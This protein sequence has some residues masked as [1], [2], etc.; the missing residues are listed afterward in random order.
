MLEL[1]RFSDFELDGARF[2]LRRAG[3][4]VTLQPKVL[5][6]LLLL[7]AERERVVSTDELFRALW[8]GERVGMTSIRRAVRGVR[9]A[10]GESA[11]SQHSVRTVRGFGYQFRLPVHSTPARASTYQAT[12]AK[13]WEA[14][15]DLTTLRSAETLPLFGGA[16]KRLRDE[17]LRGWQPSGS[18]TY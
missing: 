17:A 12:P 10:L 14:N 6:M 9:Q 4:A 2:E 18:T 13:V 3:R 8:P 11:E 7:V 16:A 5:R 1:Y 15:A